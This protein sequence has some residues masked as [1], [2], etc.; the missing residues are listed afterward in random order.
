MMVTGMNSSEIKSVSNEALCRTYSFKGFYDGDTYTVRNEV[1][2]R[3]IDCGTPG[4]LKA[5]N[6]AAIIAGLST[7]A[8]SG[9]SGGSAIKT[10]GFFQ[11]SYQSG[12]NKVCLYSDGINPSALTVGATEICPLTY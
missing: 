9:N 7:L 8:N 1:R 12:F 5:D 2:R 4:S 11:S 3:G 10:T 6:S